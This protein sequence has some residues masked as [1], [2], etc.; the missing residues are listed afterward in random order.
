MT[1]TPDVSHH[2]E[3]QIISHLEAISEN[4]IAGGG[5][6]VF[7]IDDPDIDWGIDCWAV[8]G[9]RTG[10][11]EP[12]SGDAKCVKVRPGDDPPEGPVTTW[13][14]AVGMGGPHV[15]VVGVPDPADPT[16]RIATAWIAAGNWGSPKVYGPTDLVE[17]YADRDNPPEPERVHDVLRTWLT[18][19]LHSRDIYDLS[20]PSPYRR[21]DMGL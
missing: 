10:D 8:V 15:E 3:K 11:A 2:V 21:P 6:G 18:M 13:H 14:V 9:G 20:K 16:G 1:A 12:G 5:T 17:L 4:V 19:A 7:W